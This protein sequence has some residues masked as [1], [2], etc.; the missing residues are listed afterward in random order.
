MN[1]N[2]LKAF[3]CLFSPMQMDTSAGHLWQ[4]TFMRDSGMDILEILPFMTLQLT[5]PTIV[6]FHLLNFTT[7]GKQDIP[8]IAEKPLY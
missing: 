3:V 6:L 8:N 5:Q 2:Q 4:A 7:V 1:T